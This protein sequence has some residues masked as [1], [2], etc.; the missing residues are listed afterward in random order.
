MDDYFSN[1]KVYSEN[2]IIQ[3]TENGLVFATDMNYCLKNVEKT[4]L[5][6]TKKTRVIVLE[7]EILPI[8]VLCFMIHNI[9][10]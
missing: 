1:Y 5:S 2:N 4:M 6:T 3:I 9:P 8:T 10:L 7:K